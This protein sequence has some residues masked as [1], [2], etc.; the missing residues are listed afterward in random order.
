M[1]DGW[2][3]QHHPQMPDDREGSGFANVDLGH[4]P[5]EGVLV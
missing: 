1:A 5:L 3:A 4:G 2:A